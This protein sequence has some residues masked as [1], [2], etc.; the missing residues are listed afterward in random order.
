MRGA[1]HTQFDGE[2]GHYLLGSSTYVQY[3][4]LNHNASKHEMQFRTSGVFGEF[5]AIHRPGRPFVAPAS[6]LVE[7]NSN[8]L[9]E[10]RDAT[11]VGER[12]AQSGLPASC[13]LLSGIFYYFQ[14][15][16]RQLNETL[17]LRT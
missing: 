17:A 11:L 12:S 5:G 16:P 9:E 2:N 15:A 1:L 14:D 13:F 10:I 3:E 6:R 8:T 7:H 4:T